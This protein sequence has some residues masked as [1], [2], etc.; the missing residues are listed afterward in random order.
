MADSQKLC[1]TADQRCDARL[2]STL[3]TLNL[4]L[5]GGLSSAT[6]GCAVLLDPYANAP[7]LHC[8]S[9][10]CRTQR[11][12]TARNFQWHR[13]GSTIFRRIRRFN[14]SGRRHSTGSHLAIHPLSKC[15]QITHSAGNTRASLRDL[16]LRFKAG[17]GFF[18]ETGMDTPR[19][20]VPSLPLDLA[21]HARTMGRGRLPS[22]S[23]CPP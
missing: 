10:A 23:P 1:L 14:C 12:T 20:C 22:P 21:G 7:S 17:A 13:L 18:Y 15:I 19:A 16:Y 2:R 11:A 3:K 4:R 5:G 8:I 6:A 9:M